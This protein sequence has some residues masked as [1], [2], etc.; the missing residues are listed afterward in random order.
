MLFDL[1]CDTLSR[2]FASQEKMEN[3]SCHI[4]YSKA[5]RYDTYSQIFAVYSDQ[6]LSDEENYK[7]FFEIIEYAQP[8]IKSNNKFTP[9][10]SV[11]GGKLL[12]SK[13]D[14]L[15]EL[16][17]AGV[18]FLTLVWADRCCV[19]GAHNDKTGLTSF[20]KEVVRRCFDL[21]IVP[22]IS[23][24]SD[25]TFEDTYELALQYGKPIIAT[26]SNSRSV[27][28]HNR[29][30]TDNQFEKIRDIGGIVGISLC[31]YHLSN[32]EFCD[33]DSVIAH[34]DHYM[35]LGGQKTVCLGCDLDGIDNLP[36]GMENISHIE[37]ITDR[38]LS[39]GY[40]Y[41]LAEAITY[42]NAKN[43]INKNNILSWSV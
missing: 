18:R 9:Y 28:L 15:D 35:E 22:D 33:I 16:Y 11:E 3:N 27:C 5:D 25:R 17:R 42:K 41:D 43:F 32:D 19:G 29:N 30:L 40:S 21:G 12:S 13:I 20:G 7:L 34:I 14:R 8:F 31:R 1:H 24:S 23:H 38:L 10:L 2:V 37:K 4:D 39:R 6:S 36:D 26:H